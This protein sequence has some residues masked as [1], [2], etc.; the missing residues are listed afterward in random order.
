MADDDSDSDDSDYDPTKDKEHLS[1]VDDT[2]SSSKTGIQ[3]ELK[4]MS[5]SR[6]RQFDA[7]WNEM[8]ALEETETQKR[9][10]TAKRHQPSSSSD[11]RTFKKSS[12]AKAILAGIFGKSQAALLVGT[13]RVVDQTPADD[14]LLKDTV[15]KSVQSLQKRQKVEETRKFAGQSIT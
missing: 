15:R 1:D 7:I 8:N 5:Y 6:K 10:S 11:P 2:I 9:M 4:E 14:A 13:S 12:K 3:S